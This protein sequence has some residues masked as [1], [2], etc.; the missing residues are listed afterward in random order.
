MA[1]SPA[2]IAG[3]VLAAGAG[4]RYGLP[5]A[6]ARDEDG[7]PWLVRTIGALTDAGC[8]PVIVVLGAKAAEA[9]ALLDEF[10]LT[11]SV[12]VARADDW[13]EGL[14]ASLR[15]GLRQATE[16]P[17]TH[18]QATSQQA[19]Q[20]STHL[21]SPPLLP[22]PIAVAI[23]PVDVPGLRESTVAR[24]IGT[25]PGEPDSDVGPYTLRQAGFDARPGH[26]VVIGRAHWAAL[27]GS[28]TGDTG[29]RPYLRSHD[30]RLIDCTD[31][32]TGL[33]VDTRD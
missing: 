25:L 15:A 4:S 19:T 16:L 32:E 10:G 17:A 24:L 30:V 12:V 26:P 8:S 27:I 18:P 5:K 13:V 31:L 3:L 29:A 6:L 20:R 14:S 21:Q 33:D 2:P 22:A 11:A 7:I 1:T 28:A 9:R 23:V